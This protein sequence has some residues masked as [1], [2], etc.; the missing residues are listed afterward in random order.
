MEA[1][2]MLK[3]KYREVLTLHYLE[4]LNAEEMGQIIGLS[5]SAVYRRLNKAKVQLKTLLKGWEDDG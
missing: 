4:N 1:L 2:G 5:P 3:P